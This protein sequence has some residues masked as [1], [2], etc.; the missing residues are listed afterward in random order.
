MDKTHNAFCIENI[1]NFD[2]GKDEMTE[3]QRTSIIRITA[4]LCKKF[5][6][7]INMNSIVYHHWF[8]LGTGER[9]NGNGGNK[10]CPGTNFFGGNKINDCDINFI[11]KV[12]QAYNQLLELQ[13]NSNVLKFVCINSERLNVRIGPH[14]KKH[15]ARTPLSRGVIIR[16][17]DIAENGWLKISSKEEHWVSGKFT[18]EVWKVVVKSEEVISRV[19]PGTEF[20]ESSTFLKNEELF[21][22]EKKG[23]WYK[24]NMTMEWLHESDLLVVGV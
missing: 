24:L 10:S 20:D 3:E 16:A 2:I 21:V 7:Q 14:Y 15:I 19:G 9:N 18:H 17:F 4:V 5:G 11:P 23:V 12:K 6:L 22:S 1:G 8:K 13:T